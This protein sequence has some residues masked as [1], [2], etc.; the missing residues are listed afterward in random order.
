MNINKHEMSDDELD[1]LFRESAE[2]MD[3]DFDP[4][5]WT[6]MSQKLDAVAL[7]PSSGR[8]ASPWPKRSLLLLIGLLV[9]VGGYYSLKSST[10]QSGEATDSATQASKNETTNTD[11]KKYVVTDKVDTDNLSKNETTKA[12]ENKTN[13]EIA[14]NTPTTNKENRTK[15]KISTPTTENA[16]SFEKK[17]I[18]DK[19][20]VTEKS[21]SKNSVVNTKNRTALTKKSYKEISTRNSSSSVVVERKL[22]EK[23]EKN[24]VNSA[25]KEMY[26]RNN[27][28]VIKTKETKSRKRSTENIPSSNTNEGINTLAQ[29]NSILNNGATQLSNAP[30]GSI[31]E[32]NRLALKNLDLLAP[33]GTFIKSSITLPIV[34]FEN[35]QTQAP[36]IPKST[37]QSFKKGLYLRVGISPDVSFVTSDEL[38]KFGSNSAILLEYRLNKRLSVQSGVLRSMKYYD[39]YP[40]SY[41]WPYNWPSPPKLIDIN[42]TCKMLD[43]PLNIRYDLSQK[44]LSRWFVSFGATNYVMLNEKYVYNYE[45]PNDPKIKWKMWQGKTGAYYFGVLNFSVGYE[46]QLFRK[47]S[48]Q[49]EPFFKMPIAQVGFGHVKL[50]SLGLLV[51]AKYPI[52]TNK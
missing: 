45:N 22:V 37:S 4:D 14:E 52:F 34:A 35:P 47:L 33:K 19:T 20:I 28:E 5:S 48:I 38:T 25:E 26:S 6:K 18:V 50:S 17:K 2:S 44:P 16:E 42:A 41:E 7:P 40:E 11:S 51:S 36:I 23:S 43:I 49:A 8:G 12:E 9:F 29:G 39:A 13:N 21:I 10:N 32:E 46:Y 31:I 3:F 24:N 15:N 30:T 1:H 27:A